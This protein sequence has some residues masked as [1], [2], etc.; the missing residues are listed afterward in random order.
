MVNALATMANS[1][2][3]LLLKPQFS[4]HLL[5]REKFRTCDRGILLFFTAALTSFLAFFGPLMSALS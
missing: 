1:K 4:L 2:Y 5:S 3:P